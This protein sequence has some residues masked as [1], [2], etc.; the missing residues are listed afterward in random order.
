MVTSYITD[1]L[2]AHTHYTLD[3]HADLSPG[4]GRLR[5]TSWQ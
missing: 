4:D 2:K 1:P 3:N 5:A